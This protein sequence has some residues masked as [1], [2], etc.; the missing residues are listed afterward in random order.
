MY[1]IIKASRIHSKIIAEL[2]KQTFLESHSLSASKKDLEAYTSKIYSKERTKSE[3]ENRDFIYHLIFL[4]NKPIGYSKI[5]FNSGHPKVLNQNITKLDRLYILKEF[6]GLK[7][8]KKLFD[9]NIE[10]S[11][12]NSQSG[13]WLNVW[14][15]NQRAIQFY[16]NNGFRKIDDF[17]F[18][19]S[20]THYNPN[21][22]MYLDY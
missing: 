14:V 13:M 4:N 3:L 22:Q 1:E 7:L 15:E 17:S 11:R 20:E 2:G 16:I 18:K 6:Y 10:L 12:Q 5:I 9:F 8:G 19:I 21:Y